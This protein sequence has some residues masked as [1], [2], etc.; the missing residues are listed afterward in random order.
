MDVAPFMH[1]MAITR[2]YYLILD[3]S[4]QMS[5]GQ[6]LFN[7]PAIQ[8]MEDIPARFGLVPRK[9]VKAPAALNDDHTSTTTAKGGGNEEVQWFAFDDNRPGIYIHIL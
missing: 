7:K 2:D 8:F 9:L 1:D 6:T 5:P 4:L 3:L